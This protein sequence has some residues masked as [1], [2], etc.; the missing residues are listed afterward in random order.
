MRHSSPPYYFGYKNKMTFLLLLVSTEISVLVHGVFSIVQHWKFCATPFISIELHYLSSWSNLIIFHSG[1]DRHLSLIC[2]SYWPTCL[3]FVKDECAYLKNLFPCCPYQKGSPEMF[4]ELTI[5]LQ[6]LFIRCRDNFFLWPH[7]IHSFG[8]E[9]S[10]VF[11]NYK[12][13]LQSI[14]LFYK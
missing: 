12:M 7:H 2:W 14:L 5:V 3:L 10:F 9:L 13:D 11:A 8:A 4:T 6:T 1:G